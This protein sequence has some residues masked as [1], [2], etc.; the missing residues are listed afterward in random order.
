ME[1]EEIS[2][3]IN[4]QRNFFAYRQNIKYEYRIKILKKLRSLIILHEKDIVDA[5]WKDFHK[6]EFEVIA[7]E[8]RFVIK[9]LNSAI[10]NLKKWAKT[11]RVYTPDSSF[12]FPTIM[13]LRSHMGRCWCC[14]RG[15]SLFSLHF[16]H[17]LEQLLPVI[18]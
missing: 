8:T 12:P 9:E 5:L 10:R 2:L 13:L 4:S 17:S 11:R 16:C 18:V 14:L 6:P 7:T 3:I 15:T 1:K